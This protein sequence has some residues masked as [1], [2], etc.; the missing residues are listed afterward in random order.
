MPQALR[1][2]SVQV[3]GY[4]RHCHQIKKKFTFISNQL[5]G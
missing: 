3:S 2:R 1:L 4:R 5:L